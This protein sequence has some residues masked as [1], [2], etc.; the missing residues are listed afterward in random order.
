MHTKH[1]TCSLSFFTEYTFFSR[2]FAMDNVVWSDHGETPLH[3]VLAVM[4]PSKP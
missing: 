1:R 4:L 2:E 3:A